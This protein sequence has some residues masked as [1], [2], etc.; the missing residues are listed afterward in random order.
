MRSSRLQPLRDPHGPKRRAPREKAPPT[1][2]A[3]RT[4]IFHAWPGRSDAAICPMVMSAASILGGGADEAAGFSARPSTFVRQL[5]STPLNSRA[6]ETRRGVAVTVWTYQSYPGSSS[7]SGPNSLLDEREKRKTFRVGHRRLD[8]VPRRRVARL[9]QR[10]LLGTAAPLDALREIGAL[11]TDHDRA[12]TLVHQGLDRPQ[13]R[14]GRE[15]VPSY[16]V[17]AH[18]L[19]AQTVLDGPDEFLLLRRRRAADADENLGFRHLVCPLRA[20]GPARMGLPVTLS[21]RAPTES[22]QLSGPPLPETG[23]KI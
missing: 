17:R 10:P 1:I 8:L 15:G 21:D 13:R 5:A 23:N 7:P 16:S 9:G 2:P 3:A 6:A 20:A 18:P 11:Q 4:P 19:A 22:V 12:G 14:V